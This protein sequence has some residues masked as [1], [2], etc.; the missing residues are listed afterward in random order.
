MIASNGF[1]MTFSQPV[2]IG[3]VWGT[4]MGGNVIE[5]A[6]ENK[7]ELYR[8]RNGET[9]PERNYG[10]KVYGKGIARFGDNNTAIYF[11]YNWDYYKK[12]RE[13]YKNNGAKFGGKDSSNTVALLIEEGWGCSISKI[14]NDKGLTLY[15]IFHSGC[16][17][18]SERYIIFKVMADG[19]FVKMVDTNPVVESYLGLNR[20]GMRGVYLEKPKIVGDTI[21]ISYNEYNKTLKRDVILG[22]FRFKWDDAAQWFGV[23]QVVY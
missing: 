9:I 1:A 3:R 4:P 13:A 6:T 7:G 23:E 16:V 18:G 20:M 8:M 11:H 14:P 5:N 12:D 2:E 19:K 15:L 22:E 17:R 21:S 10:N